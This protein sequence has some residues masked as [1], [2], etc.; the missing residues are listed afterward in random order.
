L[1]PIIA[2]IVSKN[3]KKQ[4]KK[5]QGKFER[6]AKSRFALTVPPP[7]FSTIPDYSP[8]LYLPTYTSYL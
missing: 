7:P 4:K 8:I 2:I 5:K 1:S 3:E 6:I